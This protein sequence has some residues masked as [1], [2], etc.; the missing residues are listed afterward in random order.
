MTINMSIYLYI[1]IY[2]YKRIYEIIML[3]VCLAT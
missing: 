2:I 3:L 1:C